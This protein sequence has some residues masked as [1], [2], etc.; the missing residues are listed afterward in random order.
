MN[1]WMKNY[2]EDIAQD[3]QSLVLVSPLIPNQK[4]SNT[5]TTASQPSTTLYWKD[6]HM[7]GPDW[8]SVLSDFRVTLTEQDVYT[9]IVLIHFVVNTPVRK[10][11][12]FSWYDVIQSY[13]FKN[14]S[15]AD[16]TGISRNW[17]RRCGKYL[18]EDQFLATSAVAYPVRNISS[19]MLHSE[20]KTRVTACR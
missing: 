8:D 6:I 10:A 16:V 13:S 4:I 18:V 14:S 12:G 3:G 7:R 19:C 2:P 11:D 1:D 15:G 20:W 5:T 9:Y 17:D